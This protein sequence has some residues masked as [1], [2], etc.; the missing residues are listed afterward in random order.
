MDQKVSRRT[1]RGH[2]VPSDQLALPLG[3]FGIGMLV[4][5]QILIGHNR[6][7]QCFIR[8]R[9]G[10]FDHGEGLFDPKQTSISLRRVGNV[11]GLIEKVERSSWSVITYCWA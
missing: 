7:G 5:I 11:K 8:G 2:D 9:F 6:P 10:S 3:L 1:N 4:G